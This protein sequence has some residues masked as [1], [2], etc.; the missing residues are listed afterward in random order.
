[1]AGSYPDAPERR[2]AWDDDGTVL[3]SDSYENYALSAGA[4]P[5]FAWTEMSQ[6]S[7]QEANDEDYG[8]VDSH[9]PT[10]TDNPYVITCVIFP[11]LRD[12]YGY[13]WAG[14]GTNSPAP[15]LTYSADT[16]NG[17]DGTWTQFTTETI[18]TGTTVD[19]WRD[20]IITETHLGVRALKWYV[21]CTGTNC[22]ARFRAMHLY[23]G[24][25]SGSTPDRLLFIDNTTGLEFNPHKDY[26]DVPRGQLQDIVIKVKNNSGSLT[27]STIVIQ[28]EALIGSSASWYTF[29]TG[30]GFG[31]TANI[32]SLAAGATS[33]AITLRQNIPDSET[34]GLHAPRLQA[35]VSSWA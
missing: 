10:G 2:M 14:A 18:Y 25:S 4:A 32:S 7:R 11:E 21:Y 33:S 27:A 24:I 13:W 12:I 6:A 26:G 5:P 35:S 17:I 22:V 16:T 9:G 19:Y 30:S 20:G 8:T 28:A 3:L 31:S 1:M 15:W 29:D 34:L 23:G